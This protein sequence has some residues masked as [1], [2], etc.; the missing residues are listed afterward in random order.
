MECFR[1]DESGYT[2][3]DLLNPEQRFQGA[4][5]IAISDADAARLIKAHFP[6][7]QAAELKY[8]ALS[9]RPSNRPRL[10]ALLSELLGSYKCVT[11]ICDKRFLLV[12]MF[13][14]Y[15]A[16]P[17]YYARGFDFYQGGE[18]YALGSLL[19]LAGPTL[20]GE[21][22][23]YAMLAAFQRAVKVKT[24]ES[25]QDLIA[26]VRR[27]R[28]T[29]LPEALGPLARYADRDCLDAI[30]A[31]EVTTDAA[32]IVIQALISR[33]E[34]MADGPY[35]IEHDQSKNLATYHDLLR[36]YIDH[37]DEVE[38]RF[39]PIS[40]IKF[41]LKLREVIQVDS[42]ASPAV[43]L[44]DVMI[45]AALEAGS[46]LI[47]QRNSGLDPDDL[48]QLFKDDQFIHMVPDTDF[49]AQKE[50]RKGCQAAEM[51][52]YFVAHFGGKYD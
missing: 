46:I 42:K 10:L 12:M 36:R 43:Q 7:L 1:V 6:R 45:G 15:G 34:V 41:P 4:A 38:F 31:P 25:L 18:N 29:E 50:F 9:K 14:D 49:E 32:M 17:Y 28:W 26:A 23:F 24:P 48:L 19:T 8:R 27:T 52:E 5:A 51:M 39:S 21:D 35:R 40:G 44:A 20:L 47:G 13:L 16:E 22:A 3:F 30:A 11:Y 33:M 2:G 37:T